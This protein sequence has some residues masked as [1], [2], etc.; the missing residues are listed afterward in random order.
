MDPR[1]RLRRLRDGMGCTVCGA[2]VP[3]ARISLVAHRDDLV[4]A[5]ADCRA[6][7]NTAIAFVLGGDPGASPDAAGSD[8]DAS[9]TPDAPP[10]DADDVLD[11]HT[12]LA[13]WTG[14]LASLVGGPAGGAR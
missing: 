2:R 10:V 4:I 8:L 6:C 12:L 11:M 5:R 3:A 14:D 7:G 1:D 13:S 9:R